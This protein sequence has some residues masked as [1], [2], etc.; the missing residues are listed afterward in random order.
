MQKGGGGGGVIKSGSWKLVTVDEIYLGLWCV[1]VPLGMVD[2]V[3]HA[4]KTTILT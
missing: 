1:Y 3:L 2:L 4:S